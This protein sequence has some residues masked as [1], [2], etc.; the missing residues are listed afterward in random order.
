MKLD[1]EIKSWLAFANEKLKELSLVSKQFFDFKLNLD[2]LANIKRNIE[3]NNQRKISSKIA[4]S[5]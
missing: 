3:D 1:K 4:I 5:S 2:E